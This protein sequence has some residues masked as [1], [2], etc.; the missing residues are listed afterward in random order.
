MYCILTPRKSSMNLQYAWQLGGS[1][2]QVLQF[3]MSVFQPGK[4][5]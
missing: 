2:A 5:W 4:V 1:S 3:V